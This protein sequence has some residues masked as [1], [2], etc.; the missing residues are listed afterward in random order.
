MKSATLQI[1]SCLLLALWLFIFTL[2]SC[3]SYQNSSYY[4][5]DGIYGAQPQQN[6]PVESTPEVDSRNREYKK[7]FS[8]LKN[9]DSLIFTDTESYTSY[10]TI[11]QT[12]EAGPSNAGNWGSD[13][14]QITVNVYDNW[15]WNSWGLGWGWNSWYGPN[16]GWGW[17]SW[18]G[19]NWGWGWN[20]WYGAG[21][22][23]GWNYPSWY[24]PYWGNNGSQYSFYQGGRQGSRRGIPAYGRSISSRQNTV[25][26]APTFGR[27]NTPVRSVTTTRSQTS[28]TRLNQFVSPRSNN[29]TIRQ[30]SQPS[31][32]YSP[33]PSYSG[34]RGG[35]FGGGGGFRGG[36][37]GSG[38]RR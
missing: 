7:Y 5:R 31:R 26:S 32:T 15:G 22:G 14:E 20:S 28:S 38:G 3:G 35:N 13:R 1:R 21:W 25:R 4:D 9:D 10:D 8:S 19:P 27:Q 24:Y 18:Y 12:R 29:N 30:S 34:S 16:W 17:N 33:T 2:V 11:Q 37:G 6:E 36:S 23:W